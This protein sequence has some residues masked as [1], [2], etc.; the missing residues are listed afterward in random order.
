MPVFGVPEKRESAR[1]RLIHCLKILHCKTSSRSVVTIRKDEH[2]LTVVTP[3]TNHR[4][5]GNKIL[6]ARISVQVHTRPDERS[7]LI[8]LG[9]ALGQAIEKLI[10]LVTIY[11]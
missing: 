2:I 7:R 10:T 6:R 8:K 11:R 4:T 3:D 9:I 5:A 1:L